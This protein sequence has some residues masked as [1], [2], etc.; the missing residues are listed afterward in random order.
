MCLFF[1]FVLF[2]AEDHFAHEI[3]Y[4]N[5]GKTWVYEIGMQITRKIIFKHFF[6]IHVN[7]T[8]KG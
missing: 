5:L 1:L 8:T 6:G 3:F 4:I 2:F 7:F